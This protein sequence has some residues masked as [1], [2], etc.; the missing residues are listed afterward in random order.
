[1]PQKFIA[2]Y[3]LPTIQ[4]STIKFPVHRNWWPLSYIHIKHNQPTI[5]SFALWMYVHSICTLDGCKVE[6]DLIDSTLAVIS[7]LDV[8][9]ICRRRRNDYDE[10]RPQRRQRIGQCPIVMM[11]MMYFNLVPQVAKLGVR[12]RWRY[13]TTKHIYPDDPKSRYMIPMCGGGST[14]SICQA[15][16]IELEFSHSLLYGICK[17]ETTNSEF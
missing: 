3:H 10:N 17:Y 11:I 14:G 5:S 16:P 1:M 12:V 7:S 15:F 6:F 4:C 13:G 9:Y 8:H 2:F